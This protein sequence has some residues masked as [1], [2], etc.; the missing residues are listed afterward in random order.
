MSERIA[1]GFCNNVDYEIV[2]NAEALEELISAYEISADELGL[3]GEIDSERDLIISIL[4]FMRNSGGGERFVSSSAIIERFAARFEKKITLGG[5]SVRA[6]IAMRAM[7][8]TAA[9]HLIT[10]NDHVRRLLPR[11]C[12]YV[13]S[14]PDDS[15]YPHLIVQFGAR[16]R[17]RAGDIDI[18]ARQPNRLIYHCNAARISMNLNEDF[19]DLIR[20]AK[21][22]L[23]S[24]FNAVQ[25]KRLLADRLISLKRILKRLPSDA[26]VFMEDGA[27]YDRSHRQLIFRELGPRIDIYSMN[28]DEMQVH[29]DRAVDLH[30]AGSV[31]CAL[32]D[33]S[34]LIPA[35]AIVLHTRRWALAY[36]RDAGRYAAALKAGVT[37]ATARFRYGDGFTMANYREIGG[38][39]PN[40]E[41][42]RFADIINAAGGDSVVCVPVAAVEQENGT[43]IGLGD[44]FV[45]GFLPALAFDSGLS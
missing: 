3:P 4:S 45:G 31:A 12:P 1:L 17:L 39:E 9:L 6:A 29:L 26:T 2:W 18:R 8:Y 42:A 13:C 44:A 30:D 15:A 5:T 40:A 10:M 35:A 14:N 16:A 7:G 19:A 22:L 34:R 24:G 43:T 28:E 32:A 20:E 37:M 36:G 11:D 27:Y 41:D 33:L 23:I 25:S 21:V 38:R